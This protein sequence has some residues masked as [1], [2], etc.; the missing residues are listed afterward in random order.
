MAAIRQFDYTI[1]EN[2]ISPQTIARG[3]VQGEHNATQINFNMTTDFR[4]KLDNMKTG[5]KKLYY[6][7]DGY[8]GAGAEYAFD[9]SEFNPRDKSI[10]SFLVDNKLTKAGGIIEIKLVI[11]LADDTGEK[12][13]TE[14]ITYS[15]KLALNSKHHKSDDVTGSGFNSVSTLAEIAKSNAKIAEEAS[16]TSLGAMERTER[17]KATLENGSEWVFDGGDASSEFD[18][19]YTVDGE[20]SESSCNPVQ[21]KVIKQYIDN[22]FLNI[23]NVADYIVSQGQ[24]RIN[25]NLYWN[26][27]KWDSGVSECWV[28]FSFRL[29]SIYIQESNHYAYSV[30]G[31]D[32][33]DYEKGFSFP[34]KLFLEIPTV[35]FDISNEDGIKLPFGKASFN[36]SK[37]NPTKD[38]TGCLYVTRENTYAGSDWVKQET[39]YGVTIYSFINDSYVPMHGSI[40]AIGRYK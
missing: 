37:G 27:R 7:F 18:I 6:R 36:A 2:S 39:S 22:N 29:T 23:T 16:E 40:R 15:V 3:G 26:W 24:S 10:F 9:S 17:V 13:E 19:E 8:D 28:N 11:T 5:D 33:N 1:T 38:N 34:E 20:M 25:D 4:E 35:I 31:I 14:I 30:I 21:N 32:G 12:T